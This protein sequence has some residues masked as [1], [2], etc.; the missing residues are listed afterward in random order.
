MTTKNGVNGVS[1]FWMRRA[2]IMAS[3]WSRSAGQ[4]DMED[5]L[6]GSVTETATDAN[7]AG[8]RKCREAGTS[9]QNRQLRFRI[10][11]M[12]STRLGGDADLVATRDFRFRGHAGH[13]DAGGANGGLEQD[14]RAELFDDFDAGI[15]AEP[16]RAFAECEMFR[17]HPHDQLAAIV[18]GEGARF[19]C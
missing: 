19:G 10:E 12:Q 17:P 6:I 4:S 7:L 18:G 11:K 9:P 15:E 14:F 1:G 16:P 3:R 5:D 2:R 13:S 8:V